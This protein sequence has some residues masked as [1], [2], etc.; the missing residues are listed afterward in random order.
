MSHE[1]PPSVSVL[2]NSFLVN[3]SGVATLYLP[4]ADA[5]ATPAQGCARQTVHCA[6]TCTK[7]AQRHRDPPTTRV[8]TDHEHERDRRRESDMRAM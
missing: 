7:L 6:R 4:C 5:N 2:G 3:E 1:R 8:A